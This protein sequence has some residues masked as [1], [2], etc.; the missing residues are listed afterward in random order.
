[1]A[2]QACNLIQ[3]HQQRGVAD[4]DHQRVV[5]LL[6]GH[7]VVAEHKF[8]RNG[9][10]QVVLNLEVLQVNELGAIALRQQFSL[11]ALFLAAGKGTGR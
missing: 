7:K 1:M 8:H 4:R 10:Q 6:D 5:L 3:H 2:E 9:A 11:G